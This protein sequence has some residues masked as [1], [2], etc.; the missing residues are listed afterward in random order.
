MSDNN[1]NYTESEKAFLNKLE[2][3]YLYDSEYDQLLTEFNAINIEFSRD[4][5]VLKLIMPLRAAIDYISSHSNIPKEDIIEKVNE[6]ISYIDIVK[7]YKDN[8]NGIGYVDGFMF[9]LSLKEDVIDDEML[10][11]E[12][13]RHEL[14]HIMGETYINKM[15]KKFP[16]KV[17]GY[18][19]EDVFSEDETPYKEN[20]YFNESAVEMFVA[21][22][23]EFR[24]I[25][26]F[27]IDIY[28]NQY[29]DGGLYSINGNLL[30]QMLLARSVSEE[31]LFCGLF[32]YNDAKRVIGRLD[33][34]LFKR[35]F[36]RVSKNM[37]Q[38]A[39]DILSITDVDEERDL[40]EGIKSKIG[41]TEML[42]IDN[43]LCP[44][45]R[46]LSEESRQEVLDNYYKVIMCERDYFTTKTN[47]RAL[48]VSKKISPVFE[49]IDVEPL[50]V[51]SSKEKNEERK[52]A[53]DNDGIDLE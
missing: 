33:R 30:R 6:I 29:D 43:F 38:I 10:L 19:L 5:R 28:T 41:E 36:T 9:G 35:N 4:K 17:S 39:E 2:S 45:L 26:A 40:V 13:L 31:D 20:E 7:E 27:G 44:S 52:R 21:Q 46:G 1:R 37:D 16:Y 22:D 49:H 48:T 23:D 8:P 42:I 47:Y 11:Y 25:N 32:D 24:V 3:E 14:T 18:T 50:V 15:F 51:N 34:S 53:N 12:F